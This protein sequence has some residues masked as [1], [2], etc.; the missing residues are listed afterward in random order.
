MRVLVVEDEALTA[1]TLVEALTAAGHH[2]IGPAY[3]SKD[4]LSLATAERPD[5]AFVDV[6]LETRGAGIAV[7]HELTDVL[8]IAVV[9]TTGAPERVRASEEGIGLMAKPY[10]PDDAAR[11]IPVVASLLAGGTPPP[12]SV[13]SSLELFPKRIAA[14]RQRLQS[15]RQRR[16]ILLVE[17]HPKDVELTMA[18]LQKC[19]VSNPIVVARDGHEA[20]E[21]LQRRR[22]P[23]E[24]PLVVLLDLKMPR[25]DGFEVLRQ[26]KAD[27][28][29]SAI[30]VV[31]LSASRHEDE[32]RRCL[33]CGAYA[34]VTKASD[35]GEF[36]RA[37]QGFECFW[38]GH[39]QATGARLH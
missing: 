26:V 13:P 23:S 14:R 2:V 11:T 30:P 19:S 24:M 5:M 15:D 12:P 32:M 31:V 39:D 1:V 8:D 17:D 7:A 21:R 36:T 9:F 34:F 37:L 28:D 18:A 16:P 22:S 3:R 35:F 4:A 27:P 10:D 20:L 25:V 33:E 6:D 38:D 29:L